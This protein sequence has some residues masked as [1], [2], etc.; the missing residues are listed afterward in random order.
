MAQRWTPEVKK[1]IRGSRVDGTRHL[2]NALSTQSRRPQVLICASAI[3]YYGSRG[4]EILT[5]T[6]APGDDFL[7]HVVVDWEKAAALA[8]SLGIRVVRLRFGMVLGKEGGALAK[9]LPPFRFGVGGRLGSGQQWTAW[10]HIDDLVN[11]IL[12]ALDRR[13]RKRRDEC[14]CPRA[15]DERRIH[16]GTR[17]RTSSP[18]YLPG[19]QTRAET[20]VRRNGRNAAGQPARH[21]GSRA[22]SRL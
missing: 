7:A 16:Q 18:C 15:G 11:L 19:S 8:E 1:R 4:D 12:F 9:M 3:G 5:E 21:P 14:H 2:V 22:K 6:S 17:R 10:I 13:F 20:S